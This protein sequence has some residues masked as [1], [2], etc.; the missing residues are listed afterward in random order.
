M[1]SWLENIGETLGAVKI[2]YAKTYRQFF[3][4]PPRVGAL[5]NKS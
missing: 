4:S 1:R 3:K 2:T 5:G